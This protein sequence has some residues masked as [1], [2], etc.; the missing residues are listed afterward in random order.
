MPPHGFQQCLDTFLVVLTEGTPL[1]STGSPGMLLN[2]LQCQDSPLLQ[3]MIPPKISIMS[4]L[5]N[6]ALEL[7]QQ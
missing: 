6:R 7:A 2:I 1:V 4:R 5:R 3:G